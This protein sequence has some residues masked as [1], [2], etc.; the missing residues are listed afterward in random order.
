MKMKINK[1]L[2]TALML[3]ISAY[4][5]SDNETPAE[6]ETTVNNT[7]TKI[8][9]SEEATEPIVKPVTT[10]VT[11]KES[12]KAKSSATFKKKEVANI[13]WRLTKISDKDLA[14]SEDE[15]DKKEIITLYLSSN[16]GMN[17][18]TGDNGYFGNYKLNGNSIS[19]SLFGNSAVYDGSTELETEYLNLLGRVSSISVSGNILTLRAGKDLLIFQ[20][21]Q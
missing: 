15:Q 16:G 13:L 2:I 5:F 10:S 11:T 6:T 17:G 12:K 19:I 14:S 20:R 21:V 3:L 1:F 7:E 4:S 9:N 18:V 8:E